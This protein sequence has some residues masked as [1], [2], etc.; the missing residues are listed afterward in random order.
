MSLS[1]NVTFSVPGNHLKQ[2][3]L[4]ANWTLGNK[5]QWSKLEKN[6]N[7]KKIMFFQ[8]NAE[9]KCCLHNGSLATILLWPQSV[10]QELWC[11]FLPQWSIMF[12]VVFWN[13]LC[14]LATKNGSVPIKHDMWCHSKY[15]LFCN[16]SIPSSTC[17]CNLDLMSRWCVI[18]I[19]GTL[20]FKNNKRATNDFVFNYAGSFS[21]VYWH[22]FQ[23]VC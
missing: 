6:K 3:Y 14:F 15:Q 10:Q 19:Y 16:I 20:V 2:C 18:N 7:Q 22:S 17:T 23:E 9:R 5:L 21:L 4:I 11:P 13:Q 8:E 1:L 12:H